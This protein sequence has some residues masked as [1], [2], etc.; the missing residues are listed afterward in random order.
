MMVEMVNF[1][2][3]SDDVNQLSINSKVYPVRIKSDAFLKRD[4]LIYRDK[5]L[6]LNPMLGFSSI[7]FCDKKESGLGAMVLTFKGFTHTSMYSIEL[8]P[9]FTEGLLDAN[10]KHSYSNLPD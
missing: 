5:Y 7:I 9:N 6:S 8:V 1:L 2:I 10:V 4:F 3:L